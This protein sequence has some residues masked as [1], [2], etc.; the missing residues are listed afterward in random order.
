MKDP[1]GH[2]MP[3]T[4]DPQELFEKAQQYL[5]GN[6]GRGN[7][8][9]CLYAMEQAAEAGHAEAMLFLAKAHAQGGLR[10][11]DEA[12]ALDWY[13][14]AAELWN[15]DAQ[16]FLDV[17]ARAHAGDPAAQCQ[18]GDWHQEGEWVVVDPYRSLGWWRKAAD[19]GHA[20]AMEKVAYCLI[21]GY[22]TDEDTQQAIEWLRQAGDVSGSSWLWETFTRACEGD[23]EAQFNWSDLIRE[24]PVG[25]PSARLRERMRWLESAAEAG[26][27]EACG[28]L[29]VTFWQGQDCARD[30][31]KAAHWAQRALAIMD[32]PE[33]HHVL[34]CL[35]L[36][37]EGVE[38]DEVRAWNH[39]EQAGDESSLVSL[40]DEATADNE[41]SAFEL[42]CLFLGTSTTPCDLT[43]ARTWLQRAASLGHDEGLQLSQ[44]LAAADAGDPD[45]ADRLGRWLL[46]HASGKQRLVQAARLFETAAEAGN[47]EAMVTLA[48]IYQEGKAMPRDLASAFAWVQRAAASGHVVA[49]S[50]WA[51]FL[52]IP[53]FASDERE[54]LLRYQ[55]AADLGD[56]DAQDLLATMAQAAAEDA[57]AQ[58]ELGWRHGAGIAVLQDSRRAEEFLQAAA[59]QG[60]L[61]AERL[62]GIFEQAR[63]GEPCGLYALA[64]CYLHGT[65]V[66]VSPERAEELR[67]AAWDAGYQDRLL[68]PAYA[69]MNDLDPLIDGLQDLLA[70]YVAQPLPAR[71]VDAHALD[72][73]HLPPAELRLF[74]VDCAMRV[75]IAHELVFPEDQRPRLAVMAA[76]DF[77]LG[78]ASRQDLKRAHEAARMA[79][80]KARAASELLRAVKACKSAVDARKRGD[81]T[82]AR[83]SFGEAHAA[84]GI[85]ESYVQASGERDLRVDPLAHAAAEACEAALHAS[86]LDQEELRSIASSVH[87]AEVAMAHA[88][89]AWITPHNYDSWSPGDLSGSVATQWVQQRLAHHMWRANLL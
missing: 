60:H 29:A 54:L 53:G 37:G 14:R 38:Q 36:S 49:N 9:K 32:Q 63:A 70:P 41:E 12:T 45:E 33:A 52:A 66:P 42:G 17:L 30:P 15:A 88:T 19:Q 62:L 75:L 58:F 59:S 71:P 47:A 87:G 7:W 69:L 16:D 40:R 83:D 51:R 82:G 22:G 84:F 68:P 78:K 39:L 3:H 27:V 89:Q 85:V 20:E 76:R 61:E 48:R 56:A 55:V 31:V 35:Y 28:Q 64:V 80:L 73:D 10:P 72:P 11:F 81:A 77:A 5:P 23:P 65:G 21:L 8:W 74:A 13:V 44:L 18:L 46:T 24:A 34:G 67:A 26:C 6:G 50:Y 79:Y 43:R 1:I 25:E 86:S 2:P 4:Q 57:E